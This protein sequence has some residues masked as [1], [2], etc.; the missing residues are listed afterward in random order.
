MDAVEIVISPPLLYTS[1][2]KER[3]VFT[4][5]I[6]NAYA[7][8]VVLSN[9]TDILE[10]NIYIRI[11][12]VYLLFVLLTNFLTL[13][14][15]VFVIIRYIS[16]L[17]IVYFTVLNKIFLTRK[18]TKCSM[19]GSHAKECS[20]VVSAQRGSCLHRTRKINVITVVALTKKVATTVICRF[21]R[22]ISVMRYAN[23]V[24]M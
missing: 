24:S 17:Y 22:G 5:K 20:P 7:Y 8:L 15:I 6:Q 23:L 21:R 11:Q 1:S 14:N 3:I 4:A 19:N 18:N 9:S 16:V 2:N 10:R 13:N 12:T